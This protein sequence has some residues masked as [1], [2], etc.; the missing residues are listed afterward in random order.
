MMNIYDYRNNVA[1]YADAN[2]SV[3]PFRRSSGERAG[4]RLL[5]G[6]GAGPKVVSGISDDFADYLLDRGVS[7][8]DP[9]LAALLIARQVERIGQSA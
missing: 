9:F 6:S 1:L 2:L 3:R 5:A 4:T 8:A 7:N